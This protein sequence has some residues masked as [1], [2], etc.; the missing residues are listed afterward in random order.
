ME[1]IKFNAVKLNQL[2]DKTQV[3]LLVNNRWFVH[4]EFTT[5]DEAYKEAR[6]KANELGFN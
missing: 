6:L 3:L 1:T 5:R 2:T 4:K